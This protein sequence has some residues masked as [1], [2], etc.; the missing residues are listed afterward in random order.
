MSNFEEFFVYVLIDDLYQRYAPDFISI[1]RNIKRSKITDSEIITISLC[2]E[3]AG[4]GSQKAWYAF[5]KKNYGFLFPTL[6]SCTRFHRRHKDLLQ[7]MELLREKVSY[8]FQ[9][10]AGSFGIVDSFSLPIC[11]F[12]RAPFYLMTYL[13]MLP[14]DTMLPKRKRILAIKFM[15]LLRLMVLSKHLNLLVPLWMIERFFHIR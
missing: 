4:V 7:V 1:R 3:I 6:C 2:R 15:L 14:I 5:V 12:A 9:I 10:E 8:F 11:K 13:L